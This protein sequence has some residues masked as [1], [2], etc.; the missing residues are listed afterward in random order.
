MSKKFI[1]RQLVVLSLRR[2]FNDT[3]TVFLI[4][5]YINLTI[6]HVFPNFGKKQDLGKLTFG[7]KCMQLILWKTI[8]PVN[9]GREIFSIIATINGRA[10]K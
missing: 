9:S 7:I 8:V 6:K 2:K 4:I 3:L 1:K 10:A 5:R